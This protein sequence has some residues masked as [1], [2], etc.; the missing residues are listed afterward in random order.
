[1]TRK[2]TDIV[3]KVEEVN[4][5]EG[6]SAAQ[7]LG[8]ILRLENIADRV[9]DLKEEKRDI[10]KEAKACGFNMTTV[11]KMYT[12]RRL[13]RKN[14]PQNPEMLEVYEAAIMDLESKIKGKN[15]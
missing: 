4:R 12:N 15:K 2:R 10:Y 6:D 11:S 5:L 3:P 1:M 14:R 7:L 9:E 13:A 8:Y